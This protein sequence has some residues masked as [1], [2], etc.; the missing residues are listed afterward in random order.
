ML[1]SDRSIK[2]AF[3]MQREVLHPREQETSK[4]AVRQK[5]NMLNFE[6]RRFYQKN[7]KT[8]HVCPIYASRSPVIR[9][10][11]NRCQMEFLFV[12]VIS[13]HRKDKKPN[14]QKKRIFVLEI[15]LLIQ[16]PSKR[17]LQTASF[18]P[19]HFSRRGEIHKTQ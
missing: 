5:W 14:V 7:I 3:E 18:I 2:A 6:Y 11:F 15:K 12:K 13:N 1:S 17:A 10:S 4:E 8:T 9:T 19:N 16:T